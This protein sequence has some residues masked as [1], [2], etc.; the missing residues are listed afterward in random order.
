M[1]G[2]GEGTRVPAAFLR[3]VEWGSLHSSRRS[4]T[5]LQLSLYA[6]FRCRSNLRDLAARTLNS[7]E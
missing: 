1:E 3:R 6:Y 7:A 5:K 2:A 4:N